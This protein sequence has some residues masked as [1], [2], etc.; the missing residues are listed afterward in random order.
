MKISKLT[1]A[2]AT[3]LGASATSGAFAMNLYV[4][5]KTKQIYAEPGPHRE[6]MGNFEKVGDASAKTVDN[7]EKADK[8]EIKA[9]REDLELKQNEIKAL[10]EH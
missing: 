10:E 1:L 3:V 9:I 2:I 8:A 7:S 6:L 4:D 5:T